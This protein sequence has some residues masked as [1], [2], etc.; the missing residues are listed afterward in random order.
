MDEI[1]N[2]AFPQRVADHQF[3][4]GADKPRKAPRNAFLGD[5]TASHFLVLVVE[6][7]EKLRVQQQIAKR[8]ANASV[9]QTQ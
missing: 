1:V 4:V 5:G 7:E 2:L 8:R 6:A 9:R 3:C